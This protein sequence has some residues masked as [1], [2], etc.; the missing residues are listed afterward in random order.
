MKTFCFFPFFSVLSFV[1]NTLSTPLQGRAKHC[2][3]QPGSIGARGAGAEGRDGL[4]VGPR[5]VP[6]FAE[7]HY[8]PQGKGTV[9][10]LNAIYHST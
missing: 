10:R 7:T 5:D 1:L 4:P 9:K 2:E 8:S 3:E 6:G